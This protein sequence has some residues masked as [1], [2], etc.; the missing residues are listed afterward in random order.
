MFLEAIRS[1]TKVCVLLKKH[2]RQ[3]YRS[4]R[5]SRGSPSA[6]LIYPVPHYGNGYGGIGGMLVGY[7]L[8]ACSN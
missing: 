3:N 6:R 4:C 5:E 7:W 8:G 2:I 1:S